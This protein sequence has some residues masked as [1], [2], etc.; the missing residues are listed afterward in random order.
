MTRLVRCRLCERKEAEVVLDLGRQP[1]SSHFTAVAGAETVQ[2]PMALSACRHCGLIQ[3]AEPFPYR[4]LTPPYDWMTFREPEKHLDDAVER[5][6]RIE[7]VH[8]NARVLGLSVKDKTTIDRM[9]RLGFANTRTLDVYKDL[10]ADYP[11]ASIESV[12]ALMTADKARALAARDGQVDVLIARHV[13]EH[14]DEPKAFLEALKLL[15]SPGGILLLEVPDC[16]G[17]LEKQDYCMLWEEHASYFTPDTLSPLLACVGLLDEGSAIYP[18]PFEDVIVLA[19]RKPAQT[20]EAS[21]AFDTAAAARNLALARAY[22]E[23]FEGWTKQYEALFDRLT[24]DG[25]KLATYGAGHLTCA[26][27][28][29]HGLARYFDVAIDDTPVKQGLH[30]PGAAL[31]IAPNAALDAKRIAA[32][33]MGFGPEVEDKVIAKNAHFTAGGGTFYSMFADSPR[34]VRKLFEARDHKT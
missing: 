9:E 3:L 24:A 30:L 33:L 29:F 15:L 32:C 10:G 13:L 1:V 7:G 27:L 19:A 28:N 12:Y 21:V 8:R 17:N 2:S 18:Y 5:L 31:T 16:R 14:A 4:T 22:G 11:N 23:A 25:R 6:I 26:F 34:S 20:G